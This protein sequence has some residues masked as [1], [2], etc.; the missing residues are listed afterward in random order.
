M[1]ARDCH[2]TV[3]MYHDMVL[4]GVDG[5]HDEVADHRMDDHENP[6]V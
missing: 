1:M 4:R 6:F 3:E 5:L 2:M